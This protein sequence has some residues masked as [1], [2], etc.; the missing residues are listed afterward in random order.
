MEG[1][2]EY[3]GVQE[4]K[5]SALPLYPCLDGKKGGKE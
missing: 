2:G 4:G 3:G 1:R 5:Y